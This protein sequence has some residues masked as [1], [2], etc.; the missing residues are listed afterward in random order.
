MDYAANFDLTNPFNILRIMCGA[1]FIP[2]LYAKFMVPDVLAFF[3]AAG[4]NPPT[5]WRNVTCTI[6]VVLAIG[7]IFAILTPFVAAAAAIFLFVAAVAV[8][9]VSGG[10]WL[11]NI[12]GCEY[13]VFW[14]LCC[15][16]VAMQG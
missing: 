12:G 5:R 8:Y 13:C 6:E 1:F 2:H 16:L 14:G 4:M 7:L 11:W 3:A 10:K 9:R 15:V